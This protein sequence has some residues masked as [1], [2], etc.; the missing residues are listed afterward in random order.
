MTALKA[1]FF[2][3]FLAILGS[4]MCRGQES[5]YFVTYDHH[6]EEPDNLEIETYTTSGIPRAGQSAYVAPYMEIEYGVTS[7]WTSELYLEGQGTIEDSA[8][9]TGWR[10]ENRFRVLKREHFI[11]P[12]L[13]LEY[14]RTSEASRIQK[15]IVGGGPDVSSPN[16]E[17]QPTKNHELEGKLILSST[18][19]DWNI[20]GNFIA[21]KNLSQAEGF[22]FGYAF[23]VARPLAKLASGEQCRFCR[24]NFLVGIELYGGLGSTEDGFSV[25]NTAHYAAPVMSWQISENGSLHFSPSIALTHEG[26]PLLLRFGYSYEIRS[27][28]SKIAQLFGGRH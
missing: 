27:F 13:Y 14:E 8:V 3:L 9:F 12:V 15:E 16:S 11:N 18:V 19:H 4:R 22:E 10:L 23:G 25:H 7:R 2:L 6:L 26:S 20:A 1:S 17:V 24:E 28:S 5:P 21:E